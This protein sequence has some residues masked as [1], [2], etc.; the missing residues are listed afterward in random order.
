MTV[1]DVRKQADVTASA[2]HEELGPSHRFNTEELTDRTWLQE[3]A[4]STGLATETGPFAGDPRALLAA[5][6]LATG[7]LLVSA[8]IHAKLAFQLGV[9]GM[10]LGRGQLF[11]VNS[12]LSAIIAIAML[13]R[14]SSRVW[15]FAVVLSG[16]GLLGILSSVY[17]PV[18]SSVGPFPS[19]YEPTWLMTKA[20]CALAELTVI[21]LWLIRRIAP[22][23]PPDEA[24]S[25]SSRANP[26]SGGSLDR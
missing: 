26:L 10:P 20:V 17:F 2:S 18:A 11:L 1:S 4:P 8:L 12:L 23:G 9:G 14:N 19:I 25:A 16:A 15:L 21:V 6:L 24:V 22:A 5:R 3:R 13:S 7:A